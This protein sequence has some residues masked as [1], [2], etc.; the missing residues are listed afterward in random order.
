MLNDV[1]DDDK[2]LLQCTMT[3]GFVKPIGGLSCLPDS[4]HTACGFHLV[5]ELPLKPAGSRWSLHY[6]YVECG[7]LGMLECIC[8]SH[9]ARV[10]LILTIYMAIIGWESLMKPSTVWT[11]CKGLLSCHVYGSELLQVFAVW[12]TEGRVYPL[13]IFVLSFWF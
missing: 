13:T 8:F 5:D 3:W 11:V 2:S 6:M 12:K 10:H 1:D 4:S 7:R 9:L